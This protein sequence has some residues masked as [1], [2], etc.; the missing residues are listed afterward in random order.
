MVKDATIKIVLKFITLWITII[1][2]AIL[3]Y[4]ALMMG[5]NGKYLTITV[6]VIAS[7]GTGTFVQLINSMAKKEVIKEV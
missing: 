3:E 5:I 6:T 4:K 1:C 2:I 7:V